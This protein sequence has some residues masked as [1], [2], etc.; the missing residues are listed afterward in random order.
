[1]ITKLFPAFIL[2]L[3]LLIP[4]GHPSARALTGEDG[5]RVEFSLYIDPLSLAF[6]NWTP[7]RPPDIVRLDAYKVAS[8]FLAG[9][10]FHYEA[11]RDKISI[12][13]QVDEAADKLEF[14]S[15]DDMSGY[16]RFNYAVTVPAEIA[17]NAREG[18]SSPG[19]GVNDD[20]S[21]ASARESARL[22]ALDE[23]IRAAI[24]VN[25][26]RQNKPIPGVIDGRITWYNITNEGPDPES[27][28]YVV[29]VDAWVDLPVRNTTTSPQQPAEPDGQS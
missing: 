29:D 23:A 26:I 18:S 11:S 7:D 13:E 24:A 20:E 27:G 1:M 4:G 10:P 6:E 17:S 25:Y 8:G 5:E 9:I 22:T 15:V 2:A 21:V 19:H 28:F 14:L 16:Y 3:L 12:T